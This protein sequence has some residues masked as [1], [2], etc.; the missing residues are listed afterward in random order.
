LKGRNIK[1]NESYAVRFHARWAKWASWIREC[2]VVDKRSNGKIVVAYKAKVPKR[3]GYT[4]QDMVRH[5]VEWID[6][7]RLEV[8]DSAAFI[9]PWSD[10]VPAGVLDGRPVSERPRTITVDGVT[11]V[12]QGLVPA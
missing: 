5:D 4:A 12:E 11:Y 9:E 10:H 6:G 1:L 8:V 7:E 3:K 2:R